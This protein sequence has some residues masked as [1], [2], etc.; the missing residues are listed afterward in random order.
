MSG[1]FKSFKRKSKSLGPTKRNNPV[2]LFRN[3]LETEEEFE[4]AKKH[5]VV[6]E[7]RV[8]IKGRLVVGRYSVLPYYKEL[9]LDLRRQGTLEK[10]LINSYEEHKYIAD[11]KYYNDIEEYTPKT[12]FELA[13][14]PRDDGPFVLKGVTNSRKFEWD[15]HMYAETWDDVTRVWGE[16][17]NDGLIGYQDIII[18]KYIPLVTFEVGV[19]GMRF[20]NEWRLFF[21]NGKLM[22]YGYYWSEMVDKVLDAEVKLN[23]IK[24]GIPFA[25]KVVNKIVDKVSFI[26]IDIA[27]KEEGGWCAIECNDGQMAGLSS[28]NP[29]ELYKNLKKELDV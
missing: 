8:G 5:F 1:R 7:S 23:F 19:N 4:V 27:E 16:L 28:N 11:F 21:C 20:T 15:T 10:R 9:V 22:S 2:I 26:A 3:T 14:V 29:D 24:T 25:K 6:T 12:Y 18:R 13:E 17:S